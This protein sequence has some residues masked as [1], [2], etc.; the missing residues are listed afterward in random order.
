MIVAIRRALRYAHR[1]TQVFGQILNP[2]ATLVEIRS[3][4]ENFADL[5]LKKIARFPKYFDTIAST[6]RRYVEGKRGW[7]RGALRG[8]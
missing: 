4:S 5:N 1:V 3:F 6:G 7:V 2:T 8:W